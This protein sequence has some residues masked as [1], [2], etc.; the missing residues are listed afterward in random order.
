[1]GTIILCEH[2]KDITHMMSKRIMLFAD[3]IMHQ[4]FKMNLFLCHIHELK[5]TNQHWEREQSVPPQ[6]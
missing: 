1:M 5:V 6:I 2:A 3:I 4:K